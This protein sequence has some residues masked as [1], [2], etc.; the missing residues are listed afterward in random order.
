MYTP[1]CPEAPVITAGISCA[2]LVVGCKSSFTS[3]TSIPHGRRAQV[4]K[5]IQE[6]VARGQLGG[7]EQGPRIGQEE[8]ES[9]HPPPQ[10]EVHG[11]I[12][13]ENFEAQN[14][15]GEQVIQQEGPQATRA[16]APSRLP[17]QRATS[18]SSRMSNRRLQNLKQHEPHMKM[19]RR[20]A[21]PQAR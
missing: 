17:Y 15:F 3:T 19:A 20:P 14:R 10:H 2:A 13:D 5:A 12:K 18:R 8:G 7:A 4:V 6:S 1:S 9:Q 21:P 16:K 11:N